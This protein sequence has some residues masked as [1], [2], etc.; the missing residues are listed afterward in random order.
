MS[1]YD[2]LDFEARDEADAADADA[3][4]AIIFDLPARPGTL[5]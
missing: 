4:R 1:D 3:A 5:R 2:T